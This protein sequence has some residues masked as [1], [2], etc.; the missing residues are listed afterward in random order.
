MN[1]ML[2]GIGSDK[3]LPIKAGV[4]SLASDPGDRF[5]IVMTNPPFGKK[6]STTIVGEEGEVSKERDVVERDDFWATT[7]NK[8][9]N[10]VQHVK[11]LL[12]RKSVV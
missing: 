2:H 4:D 10:F 5:D 7:S 3:E 8:Q 12:D 9:L 11:T 6:S 1:L